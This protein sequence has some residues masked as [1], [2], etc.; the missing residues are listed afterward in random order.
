MASTAAGR[1]NVSNVL[2]MLVVVVVVLVVVGSCFSCYYCHLLTTC[3]LFYSDPN[4]DP[5][6]GGSTMA[7]TAAGR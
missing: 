1:Y 3:F 4:L 2:V 5:T 7:S 6:E